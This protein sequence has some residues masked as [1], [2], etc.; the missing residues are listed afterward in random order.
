MKTRTLFAVL[1]LLI[2]GMMQLDA[3]VQMVTKRYR[4]ATTY[5]GTSIDL[6]MDIYWDPNVF[7]VTGCS[8]TD[9]FHEVA[10]FMHGGYF[11]VGN[12]REFGPLCQELASRGFVAAT[13]S[14]RLGGY[15]GGAC[16]PDNSA[17]LMRAVYRAGQDAHAASN[18]LKNNIQSI[19]SSTK[20]DNIY[21]GGYSAGAMTALSSA[22]LDQSEID[23]DYPFLSAELGPIVEKGVDRIYPSIV[24]SIGGGI[25]GSLDYVTNNSRKTYVLAFAGSNDG[26]VPYNSGSYQG[27]QYSPT[28][29]GAGG[30]ASRLD[31]E[32]YCYRTITLMGGGHSAF[33][34][35][36]E[37]PYVLSEILA[38]TKAVRKSLWG[39]YGCTGIIDLPYSSAYVYQTAAE[40]KNHFG[41]MSV[42]EDNV[43]TK[44]E[45][46]SISYAILNQNTQRQPVL[47]VSLS[48]NADVKIQMYTLNGI[49]VTTIA[50]AN[51]GSGSYEYNLP[52]VN[53]GVYML[54]ISGGE[55]L[56]YEKVVIP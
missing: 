6:Y 27:C 36:V 3:Q 35:S 11:L 41:K 10:V 53:P 49:L 15:N 31:R 40:C 29:Y 25:S 7:S 21:F 16:S 12:R 45:T 32:G 54:R 20:V 8:A 4:T 37:R 55:Y 30:F 22:F 44:E 19:V 23:N 18:W 43:N 39:Q 17:N 56:G 46:G 38:Y 48:G 51:L 24:I 13:I 9:S 26:V 50:N 28:I 42:Q 34:S 5:N 1:V 52:D 47:S 14:Y 2:T 33:T